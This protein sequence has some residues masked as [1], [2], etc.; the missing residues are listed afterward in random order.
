M[1]KVLQ[2]MLINP[3]SFLQVNG[4]ADRNEYLKVNSIAIDSFIQK[5]PK[6]NFVSSFTRKNTW[7]RLDIF[8]AIKLCKFLIE[9]GVN[10]N[11]INGSGV[12]LSSD[13]RENMHLNQKVTFTTF[14]TR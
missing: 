12:L 8:R 2:W 1:N 9:N 4:Y 5:Y 11:R 7:K 14:I 10:P 3:N 6:F 13:E